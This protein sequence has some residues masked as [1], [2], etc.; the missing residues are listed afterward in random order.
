MATLVAAEGIGICSGKAAIRAFPPK[1]FANQPDERQ[2]YRKPIF[3]DGKVLMRE[4]PRT[5]SDGDQMA[6]RR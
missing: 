3:T 2:T 6:S 1:V 5:T 4:Y